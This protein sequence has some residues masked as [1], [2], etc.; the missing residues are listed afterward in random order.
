MNGT[1][2]T[3][4]IVPQFPELAHRTS[5]WASGWLDGPGRAWYAW[6]ALDV[7]AAVVLILTYASMYDGLCG[8]RPPNYGP[9]IDAVTLTRRSLGGFLGLIAVLCVL[10]PIVRGSHAVRLYLRRRCAPVGPGNEADH[11]ILDQLT[12]PRRPEPRMRLLSTSLFVLSFVFVT[13]SVPLFSLLRRALAEA[14]GFQLERTHDSHY[15]Q[16]YAAHLTVCTTLA[17]VFGRAARRLRRRANETRHD[18]LQRVSARS[19]ASG[20][21]GHASAPVFRPFGQEVTER[22]PEKD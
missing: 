5:R 6:L 9:C 19:P 13:V 12:D 10:T 3:A 4:A 18:I 2:T 17:L 22:T 21:P 11:Q 1:E 14:G 7:A 8:I 15:V 20:E 16:F